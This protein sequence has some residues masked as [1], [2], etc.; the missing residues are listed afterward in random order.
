MRL[1]LDRIARPFVVLS[2]RYYPDP[3]VFAIALTALTLL[4]AVVNVERSKLVLNVP[5]P[6]VIPTAAS[7]AIPAVPVNTP[8]AWPRLY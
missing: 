3:F 7:D 5:L 6:P 2:E 4:G 1:S 8:L